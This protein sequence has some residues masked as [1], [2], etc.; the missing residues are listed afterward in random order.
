M[1]EEKFKNHKNTCQKSTRMKRHKKISIFCDF[2]KKN[3]ERCPSLTKNRKHQF[4][5]RK[6]TGEWQKIHLRG[7]NNPFYGKKHTKET[8]E[9][10][11]KANLGKKYPEE[12]NKKKGL[13]GILNPFFGKK[14]TKKTR[15]LLRKLSSEHKNE[16]LNQIKMLEEQGYKCWCPD[17]GARP[18]IVAF[19]ENKIYAVEVEFGIPNTEKYKENT[20]FNDIFWIIKKHKKET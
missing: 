5:S 10:G 17:S 3:I 9:K 18:D 6:C 2:C 19:K 8:L 7:K 16:I 12:V 11:L 15:K 4:C 20:F 1:N 13:P 14:H